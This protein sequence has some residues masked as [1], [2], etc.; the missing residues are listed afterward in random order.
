MIDNYQFKI[1]NP[2][3]D[4]LSRRLEPQGL[5]LKKGLVDL[6]KFSYRRTQKFISQNLIAIIR[7]YLP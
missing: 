5:V 2:E 6:L 4:L 1:R 7:P 3:T